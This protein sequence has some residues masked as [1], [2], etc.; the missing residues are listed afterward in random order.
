LGYPPIVAAAALIIVSLVVG[1]R[2]VPA[3]GEQR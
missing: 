3:T 1:F 2:Q